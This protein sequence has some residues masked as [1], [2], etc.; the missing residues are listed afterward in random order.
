MTDKTWSDTY[1]VCPH[2]GHEH[3]DAWEYTDN[4]DLE[5]HVDCE[6]C[7]REFACWS[8]TSVCYEAKAL[9]GPDATKAGGQG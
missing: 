1:I 6:E 7:E 3:G 8:V 9:V 5:H 2:C 4:D